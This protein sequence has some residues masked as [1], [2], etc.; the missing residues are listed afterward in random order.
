VDPVRI[1]READRLGISPEELL[2]RVVAE[3]KARIT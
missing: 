3:V 2:V 1:E